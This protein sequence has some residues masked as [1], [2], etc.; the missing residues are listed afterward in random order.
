MANSRESLVTTSKKISGSTSAN[1]GC[2]WQGVYVEARRA[3]I[4]PV[5][6]K[7]AALHRLDPTSIDKKLITYLQLF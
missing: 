6:E 1:P 4:S 2:G 7:I 5:A 3:S